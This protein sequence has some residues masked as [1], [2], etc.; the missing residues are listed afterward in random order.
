MTFIARQR[1]IEHTSLEIEVV[2]SVWSMPR[3]YKGTKKVELVAIENWV[4]FWRW[5]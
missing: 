2:F 5:Q 3:S 4:E 1:I